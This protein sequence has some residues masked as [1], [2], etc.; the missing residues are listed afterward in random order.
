MFVVLKNQNF[1]GL[2]DFIRWI[3]KKCHDNKSLA[4][5]NNL[6]VDFEILTLADRENNEAEA[7]YVKK[8]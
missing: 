8:F 2:I 7:V 4:S 5:N 1:S 3:R 6:I